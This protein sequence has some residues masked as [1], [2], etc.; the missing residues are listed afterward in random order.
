MMVKK[1]FWLF[2]YLI[3][4]LPNF[5]NSNEKVLEAQKILN[6]M[7]YEVLKNGELDDLTITA[8][9][10]FYNDLGLEFDGVLDDNEV[11]NLKNAKI[12]GF[13]PNDLKINST[14]SIEN[15]KE[16]QSLLFQMG[17]KIKETNKLDEMT[18]KVISN[19]YADLSLK[20]DGTLNYEK[21]NQ[22]RNS[23]LMP[24][25]LID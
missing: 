20:Y 18:Q 5:A 16:I 1:S 10:K 15:I 8:I 9:N 22:I 11:E 4:I 24:M 7:G 23:P 12:S 13:N 19:F 3:L 25:Q 6:E 2:I 21:I 14:L 17:Y